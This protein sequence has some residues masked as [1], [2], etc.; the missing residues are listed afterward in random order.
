MELEEY[1]VTYDEERAKGIVAD[2]K[3]FFI[4]HVE[5]DKPPLRCEGGDFGCACC[6][7]K[8]PGNK[9]GPEELSKLTEQIKKAD[10]KKVEPK[11]KKIET[12]KEQSKWTKV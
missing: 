2:I 5:K 9:P 3:D 6:W 10:S 8:S 12:K 7:P 11:T 1:E 4:N